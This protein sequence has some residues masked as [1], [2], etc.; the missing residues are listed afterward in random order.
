MSTQY[1]ILIS[2][3]LTRF[4]DQAW[5][6]AVPITLMHIYPGQIQYIAILYLISKIAQIVLGPWVLSK[7][8]QTSRL[9]IYKLGIGSQTL[10]LI[11]MWGLILFA[12]ISKSNNQE[13]SNVV[14]GSVFFILA[15]L[16]AISNLGS[17]LMD[18]SVG[19]DLAVDVLEKKEMPVFNSRLKRIDLFTEVSAPVFVGLI[20]TLLNSNAYLYGFSFVA[21]LNVL[22]FIPEYLLLKTI[23]SVNFHKEKVA[24]EVK[25]SINFVKDFIDALKKLKNKPYT[26]VII[27]YALLWLSVLSPHGVLLTSYLK[28]GT[29]TSELVIGIFRGAGAIFGLIPTFMF[30]NLRSRFGLYKTS[31]Y[32]LAFQFLTVL[33]AGISF[34]LANNIYIFL[35]LILFS[36]IGLYGASIGEIELRQL[37]I[38]ANKRGEVNGVANSITSMATVI[39]FLLGSLLSETSQFGILIGISIIAVFAAL[40]VFNKIESKD[41]V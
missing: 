19:F 9:S 31:N 3:F 24:T 40:I 29:H 32:F 18:V 16:G 39:L 7:I 10:A 33:V 12:S 6:F 17:S 15:L 26:Y 5:D 37:M 11:S 4:G 14:N 13:Y 34:Y 23:D 36:R 41:H 28:D 38:P 21:M 25:V 1:K 30:A 35:V 8:D 27:S 22:T 2:R 20:A